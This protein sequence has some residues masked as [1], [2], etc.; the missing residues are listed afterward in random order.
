M[1]GCDSV[2][3]SHF[4]SYK[5][6]Y[7]TLNKYMT[8]ICNSQIVNSMNVFINL[9]DLFHTLHNP[10]INNEFQICGKDASK[11]MISN[12]FNLIAHY[13]YWAIKNHYTCKVYCIYTTT[14]R[15][16]KN[17][18]YLPEYRSYYK[19]IN[20][21]ENS[22]CYFV[23]T[24][25]QD[26]TP[27]LGIISKYIP[28]VYTI[29]SKYLE[30]S[31]IPLFISEEVSKADWNLMISRDSYDLQYA[32]RNKWSLISPKG[33]NSRVV[34]Q[35]GI[36]NYVNY[37][38]KVFKDEVD[39][40]YPY[41]MYILSKAVVGDKYRGI[42]RLRKIGWK[43]LFKFLDE[44]MSENSD[45][46]TTTLKIKLIEKIKGRS[47]LSNTDINNNLNSINVE[48]Q[49]DAMM[50]IDKT[51]ITSQIIDVPDYDNLQE[52]NRTKFDKY[53]LNLQFLCNNQ[54]INRMKTPFD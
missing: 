8:P 5:V 16:F 34:N 14:M 19:K 50:E 31:M 38:E 21:I 26:T 52:L 47:M 44:V 40:K 41:D 33:D 46:S 36:W 2:I 6:K 24:S 37:K 28:D 35:Q 4:N 43:T 39:L 15:S 51:L 30:P 48:L 9:D 25:I 53:P 12:I 45:A 27:L 3:Q 49:Y 29:D 20:A 42:P 18:V 32:Y 54:T 1:K 13:R 22:G 11:Q 10:L 17:N 7:D 23:N